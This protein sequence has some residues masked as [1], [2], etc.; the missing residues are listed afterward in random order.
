MKCNN[1]NSEMEN[2]FYNPEGY[3]NSRLIVHRLVDIKTREYESL[4]I[5]K[6][7]PKCGNV[8]VNVDR[9]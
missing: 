3:G 6:F 4:G 5:M 8:Q 2:L 1:C 7:C 9:E